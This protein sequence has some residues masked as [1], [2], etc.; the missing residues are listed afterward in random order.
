MRN[1]F[2]FRKPNDSQELLSLLRLRYESF[3]RSRLK[4]FVKNCTGG[5]DVDPWDGYATHYGL[6]HETEGKEKP[7]GYLRIVGLDISPQSSLLHSLACQFVEVATAIAN[8]REALLPLLT[9]DD[10]NHVIADIFAKIRS[11]S[12][13]VVEP[14]RISLSHEY[15]ALPLSRYLVESAIA[16]YF[17]GIYKVDRAILSCAVQH[18]DFYQKFG[19]ALI[20]GSVNRC[21]KVDWILAALVGS[22]QRV[23][24]HI[25]QRV[26]VLAREYELTGHTTKYFGSSIEVRSASTPTAQTVASV[27]HSNLVNCGSA[28]A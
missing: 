11:N 26:E 7:V 17:A 16:L 24:S 18:S 15:Q 22:P 25:M 20:P 2:V 23:P 4:G 28:W 27:Q 5:L 6:Y 3:H 10:P 13:S 19:F 9:Y 21:R 14:G 8:P 1:R 12:L